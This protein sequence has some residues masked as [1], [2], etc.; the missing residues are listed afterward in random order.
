MAI[1]RMCSYVQG[2]D[3]LARPLKD[4]IDYFPFD[5]GFLQDKKI[6]L[7]KGEFGAKGVLVLLQLLCSI[8]KESGYFATCDDDDCLL[9]ADAVGCGVDSEFIRQ[10]IHGCIRRSLFDDKL[11]NVFGVLTSRGIQR[12]YLRA[13]STRDN[14][15]MIEEYWLLDIDNKKDVPASILKKIAFKNISLQNNEVNLQNNKVDLQKN[16]LKKSR[17]KKSKEE[18][19]IPTE[20]DFGDVFALFEKCGF[21]ITGYTA[22]ELPV[23]IEKYSREWVTEAIRR[24]ADRGKK[25]MSYIKGILESWTAAGAMDDGKPQRKPAEHTEKPS[26]YRMYEPEQEGASVPMPE[27]L[28]KKLRNTL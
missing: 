19:E 27:E 23:L 6:R 12:R 26:A 10:V 25:S 20:S 15:E 24:A 28:R 21:Q 16:P 7:I 9:M 5:V 2:G 17:V 13:L 14:I 22:E 1:C 18:V 8:Y 3:S 11:F 4:G